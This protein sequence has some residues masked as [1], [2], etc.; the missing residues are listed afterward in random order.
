MTPFDHFFILYTAFVIGII[1]FVFPL[2]ISV[3]NFLEK[4]R[5][6]L[7]Q[8]TILESDSTLSQAIAIMTAPD[9]N[10][11]DKLRGIKESTKTLKR[12]ERRRLAHKFYYSPQF[13]LWVILTPL[14][15]S[16]FM[17]ILD[18]FLELKGALTYISII[19]FIIAMYFLI[20]TLIKTIKIL[21]EDI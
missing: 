7:E 2:I 1:C 19:P 12:E 3:F 13:R 10:H 11:A 6:E 5:I 4:K 16:L 9:A 17:C 18:I 8:K 15:I 14:L 21:K 20:D